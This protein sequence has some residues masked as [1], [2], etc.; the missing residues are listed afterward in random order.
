V[1]AGARFLTVDS[2]Y[3]YSGPK[4]VGMAVAR[5]APSLHRSIRNLPISMKI[6]VI[7][8]NTTQFITD[9][10]A[11]EARRI[12]SAD[13]EIEA[14]T[15]LIGAGVISGRTENAIGAYSSIELAAEHAAGCDAVLVAVSFDS[16]VEALREL[17]SIPVV[18]MTEAAA[19]TACMLGGKFAV[20]TFGRRAIPI[21]EELIDYYGLGKRLACVQ[22]MRLPPN[23]DVRELR[24]MTDELLQEVERLVAEH[25]AESV[26]LCG[27]IFAGL[28]SKLQS[29]SPVPLLDGVS[30][31]VKQ[32]ELL[33][34]IKV[35]KPTAGSYILPSGK[36]LA[37][38]SDRLRTM[39]KRF[40]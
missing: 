12:A 2:L 5:H 19:L 7:N 28:A 20:V 10:V 23:A 27:A 36:E 25:R 24:N 18:G 32:A 29:R 35:R 40:P 6:L 1:A 31:G 14:V 39:F 37:S 13:T 22:G 3:Q 11:A 34:T 21:Y 38:V 30:C 33:A 26:Y 17:L 8:S 15:G 16:G 9:L 4:H